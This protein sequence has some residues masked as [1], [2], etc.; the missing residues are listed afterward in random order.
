MEILDP[1]LWNPIPGVYFIY[2]KENILR[3]IGRSK[4]IASRLTIHYSGSDSLVC[5]S[6]MGQ[7]KYIVLEEKQDRLDLERIAIRH[8]DPPW[9]RTPATVLN[10][11]EEIALLKK[12]NLL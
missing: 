4:N 7:V 2:D 8:F 6:K 9:N 11:Q 5:Y 12:H 10:T 1:K 3:Y